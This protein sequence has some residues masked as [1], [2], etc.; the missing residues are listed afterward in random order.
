M[1]V[2]NSIPVVKEKEKKVKEAKGYKTKIKRHKDAILSIHS[3]DGLEGQL[4]ISGSA[5]HTVRIW[6]LKEQKLTKKIDV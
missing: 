3:V 6:N 4:L 1:L 2:D 5:D